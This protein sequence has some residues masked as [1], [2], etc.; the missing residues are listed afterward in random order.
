MQYSESDLYFLT[1]LKIFYHQKEDGSDNYTE[2]TQNISR[3]F[4]DKKIMREKIV[5]KTLCKPLPQVQ[6]P[7]K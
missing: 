5:N 6:L 7:K 3:H 2:I 1:D 4:N